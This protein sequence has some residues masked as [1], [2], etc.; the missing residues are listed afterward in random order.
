MRK[1]TIIN[2][3][4]CDKEFYRADSE[5]KRNQTLGRKN[6]CSLSCSSN[7][8]KI[9]KEKQ[10]NCKCS[11]CGVGFW[12]SKSKKSTKSG[13]NFCS[14][15]CK[16]K[17]QRLENDFKNLQ[18]SHYGKGDGTYRNIIIR[19]GKLVSCE[20]CG[21]KEEPNILEV[22]HKDRDRKNNS[23]VNLEVLCPN[24]HTLEHYKNKD[25]RYKGN[26]NKKGLELQGVVVTFA[27]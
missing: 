10:D 22:H 2:C 9:K 26:K 7:H 19:S 13:Y 24:C 18:P 25:G 12:K 21:W 1:S 17:A 16:D 14:R 4:K 23:E 5:I 15:S 6:Y 11:Y 20:K 27:M 8:N 3:C